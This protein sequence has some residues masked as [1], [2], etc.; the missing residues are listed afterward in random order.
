MQR[1]L[2]PRVYPK[3]E[4]IEVGDVYESSARLD[5]GGD[6]YDFLTLDDG[7]LAV[8][9]GDVT[10]HG[11][12]AAADM[13]MAKFVFRSL[14]REHPEPGDFL[15]AANEVVVGEVALSKFITMALC[16]GRSGHGRR[17]LRERGP[18]LSR[19]S[20]PWRARS[21]HSRRVGWPW[22]STRGRP[23]TRSANGFRPAAP[24]SST[25]TA[26]SRRGGVRAVRGRAARRAARRKRRPARQG[27]GAGGR[28]R[29]PCV[30]RRRPHR[31]L[32]RRGHPQD[33]TELHRPASGRVLRIAHRGGAAIAP[34][35]TLAAFR[36]AIEMGVDFVEFDVFD[37]DDGTLVVAHSDDLL[38]V[39]HGAVRG[40]VKPLALAELRRAR[41][42]CPCSTKRS[43][44]SP[45]PRWA[46]IS[47]SS[48]TATGGG[49]GRASPS[50]AL[51]RAIASSFW[52]QALRDLRATEPRLAIGITYPEDR[53]GLARRRLL[54]PLVPG[55]VR[56][57][58]RALP[59]RLDDVEDVGREHRH[60]PLRRPLH[61]AVDRCHAAGA[62][63]WAWT[64][65]EAAVLEEA[66]SFGVD[67]VCS[68]GP[69]LFLQ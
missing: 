35:N 37:L 52:V 18:P 42:T 61:A 38:E 17:E 53:H 66:M 39:S 31:R 51:D 68:G 64:V 32:R 58:G 10:G 28:R 55:T 47:T 57:L 7:R 29:L 56:L 46:S 11:I 69:Q 5:V 60:A 54:A 6:V 22:A 4:G 63:V 49:C 50:R 19:G 62:A 34:E 1:S 15:S 48:A 26:S 43:R 13:A 67:G 12:D 16:H 24:S 36:Q 25:P 9:L 21:P 41:R 65:N 2:L 33:L 45:R 44:S 20:S 8:A 3:L 59:Y 23:T 40:R 30:H 27:A 14:A